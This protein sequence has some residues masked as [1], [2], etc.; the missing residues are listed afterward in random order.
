ME[1]ADERDTPDFQHPK[2]ASLS[3]VAAG[4]LLKTDHA[5]GDAVQL[6]VLR[7]GRLVVEH[8]HRAAQLG[9][10][11]LQRQYLPAVAQRRLGQQSQ[12]R[13][14]VQ[15]DA[16]GTFTFDRLQNLP[17]GLAK[18]ELRRMQE[19]LL[20]VGTDLPLRRELHQGDAIQ[21]PVMRFG[22]C[23]QFLGRLGQRDIHAAFAEAPP[24]QQELQG[25]RRLACAGRA[26]DQV[27]TVARQATAKDVVQPDDSGQGSVGSTA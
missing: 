10:T 27:Q 4:G 3:A 6:H 11:L 5:V 17:G 26:L 23:R 24:L 14:A 15:D 22:R 12:F 13:K 8:Q 21:R 20:P 25:E 2:G 1:A 7:L 16:I 18:L 19:G 9:E